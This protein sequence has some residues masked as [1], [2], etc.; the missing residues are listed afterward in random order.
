LSQDTLAVAQKEN[1]AAIERLKK[2]VESGDWPT[3]YEQ[4]RVLDYI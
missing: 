1:E 4:P 3:G 2:C